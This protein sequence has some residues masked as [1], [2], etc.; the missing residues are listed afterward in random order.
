LQWLQDSACEAACGICLQSLFEPNEPSPLV[1]LTCFGIKLIIMN[2]SCMVDL[3]HEACLMSYCGRALQNKQGDQLLAGLKSLKCPTCSVPVLPT[4]A[5]GSILVD[6]LRATFLKSEWRAAVEALLPSTSI[7]KHEGPLMD[8]PYQVRNT[9]QPNFSVTMPVTRSATKSGTRSATMVFD[10]DRL[11]SWK[12]WYFRLVRESS[13]LKNISQYR[14]V[15]SIISQYCTRIA[16]NCVT[17]RNI[18]CLSR[19]VSPRLLLLIVSLALF[20]TA[21]FLFFNNTVSIQQ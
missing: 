14:S 7:K 11:T 21:F 6:S 19:G 15:V 4:A 13:S 10:E 5:Q 9:I 1:R 3:F 12:R 20:S 8:E 2:P 16:W 17:L 18:R